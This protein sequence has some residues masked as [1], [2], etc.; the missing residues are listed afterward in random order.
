[1]KTRLWLTTAIITLGLLALPA[2]SS[3]E[4]VQNTQRPLPPE[5]AKPVKFTFGG[6]KNREFLLDG[7]P[8]QI[9][10]GEMHP[11]RI[12]KEYWQHRIRAAK[13]MGLNTISFYVFWNGVE[14][15]DGSF[16]FSG[17]ND[18]AAFMRLCQQDGMWVLF[19]PG[20][21]G[22][23][24][25]DFGGLP[26]YLLKKPGIKLRTTQDPDF[27]RAQK[28]WL[29]AVSSVAEP[30]LCKNGGPILLTQIENEYGSYN[31]EEHPNRGHVEKKYQ[32]WLLDYWTSKRFGPFYT[33]DGSSPAHLSMSLPG[34]AIGLDPGVSDGHF[35]SAHSV[36]GDVPV[37]SS[38]SYPG[39]LRHWYEGNWHPSNKEGHIR[40]YMNTGRSFCLYMFHGGTSFGFSAGANGHEGFRKN[41]GINVQ[42]GKFQPDLTSYDYGAPLGE[43]G[44]ITAEYD[45]YR[46]IIMEKLP[47]DAGIPEKP[48]SPPAME[49]PPF[50]PEFHASLWSKGLMEKPIQSLDAPYFEAFDQNLGMAIYRTEVPAGNEAALN[51]Q[52]MHDYCQVYLDGNFI[53][54]MN[55]CKREHEIRIPK[56]DQPARLDILV[57]TFGHINFHISMEW[58]RKGIYGKITLDGQELKN[59]T[60]C[61]MPLHASQ[62]TQLPT[63]TEHSKYKGS[64]FRAVLTLSETKDTFLDMSKYVKGYVWVN[65]FN[66][67]RYW[68]VGPQLRL[69]CPAPLLK[70]GANII[71]I[72]DMELTE[73]Q[74]IRGMP[75][76]NMGRFDR[77]TI[78]R[79]NE[80]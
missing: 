67:G 4:A 47:A 42:D 14:Q 6:D 11:Q 13:A 69:Y 2:F 51:I 41:D 9:R 60:V 71:H 58:D 27:M 64:I 59:W 37:F 53:G 39:W 48:V 7:K 49:I 1:M 70:K 21:Y 34:V 30:Y 66:L 55:R 65:G 77:N 16:S 28:R 15:P 35:N 72:L 38:E 8:F 52:Y 45:K 5:T 40:G 3:P 73:P 50:T 43:S 23:G 10:G 25:W 79:N 63:E 17:M 68:N 61:P 24:E 18:I 22:C 36:R 56:R 32:E 57:D 78:N 44:N 62:I 33:A 74:Q 29:D 19:R 54:T 75:E 12:P 76:R 20:P 80:W 26:S 31:I 46:A